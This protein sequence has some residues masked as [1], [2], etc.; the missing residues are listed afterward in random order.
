MK[1]IFN[2]L[3]LLNGHFLFPQ[4]DYWSSL[5]YFSG[6]PVNH[7]PKGITIPDNDA[8]SRM[9]MNAIIEGNTYDQ[10][11]QKYPDSLDIKLEKLISGKVIER[12][13]HGFRL[14][15]PV[16]V[17]E[18]RTELQTILHDRLLESKFSV[19]PIIVAL[20]QSFSENPEM[21]FHFLWSRIMDDCWWD[22]FNST[23][24]IDTGPPSLA[25]LVCP[26][27]PFQCGTNSDYSPDNDMFAMSWSYNIFDEFFTIP[28]SKA[29]FNL[30]TKK[31]VEKT[32][33]DFFIKHGLLDPEGH[34]FIF[35]YHEGGPLDSL[36]D[37]LK[38][39]YIDE[40]KGLF[41]YVKLGETFQIPADELFILVLHEVAYEVI[42]SLYEKKSIYIP[43]TAE[44]NPTRDFRYLIS[45]RFRK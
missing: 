40:V 22:L 11:L 28:S 45:I 33:E 24:R 9:I 20:K 30:A 8:K 17:G 16:L 34:S 25:F 12:N 1:W 41:D 29:F 31:A 44:D 39:Y 35:T 23:F 43:I 21:I 38:R 4:T 27:H 5:V 37:S 14:L 6:C 19:D 36:C 2:I 15:F 3:L 42:Q 32:D 18:K 10:L 7:I 26:P 13:Q